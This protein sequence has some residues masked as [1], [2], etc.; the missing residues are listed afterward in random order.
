MT[1]SIPAGVQ[2]F[3]RD[4]VGHVTDSTSGH[5]DKSL[6]HAAAAGGNLEQLRYLLQCGVSPDLLE[7]NSGNAP[8]HIATI[9]ESTSAFATSGHV[10]LFE[11]GTTP[12]THL[13]PH[14]VQVCLTPLF[15]RLFH[16]CGKAKLVVCETAEELWSLQPSC[17]L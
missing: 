3:I 8:L 14:P 16:F 11:D 9:S 17:K 15:E 6:L 2:D 13:P 1:S 7:E 4:H 10:T 5:V 12:T